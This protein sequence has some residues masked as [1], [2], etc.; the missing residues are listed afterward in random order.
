MPRAAQ[1]Q[2]ANTD[3]IPLGVRES[4]SLLDALP[5]MAAAFA[6]GGVINRLSLTPTFAAASGGRQFGATLGL[7]NK[8]QAI[9]FQLRA[10][11]KRLDTNSEDRN[12]ISADAKAQL[13]S[14]KV[15][16]LALR[17]AFQK[18]VDVTT[19]QD[20]LIAA[21]RPVF[22]VASQDVVAGASV[23]YAIVD[24]D[25]G[26][27]SR[28]SIITAGLR[29]A[30]SAVSVLEAGYQFKAGLPTADDFSVTLSQTVAYLRSQ[31][32]LIIVV[33]KSRVIALNLV[34]AWSL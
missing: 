12:R 23:A 19:R 5:G 9:P 29:W 22:K 25:S 18:T 14:G 26:K 13:Y 3:P 33:G 32:T 16:T 2:S 30:P 27:T 31:P 24:P 34:V 15:G 11:Y 7:L 17:G 10:G 4:S 28:G 1:A 21:D 6:A 8:N 20:Y